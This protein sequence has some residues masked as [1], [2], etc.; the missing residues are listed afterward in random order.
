[1]LESMLSC[2]RIL[3]IILQLVDAHKVLQVCRIKT[4]D[5]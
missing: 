3:L 1:M 2:L 4:R 5:S